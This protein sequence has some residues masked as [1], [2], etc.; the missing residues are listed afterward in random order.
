MKLFSTTSSNSGMSEVSGD[1]LQSNLEELKLSFG[2]DRPI[3]EL[4]ISGRGAV[5]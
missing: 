3:F 1:F 2:A 4:V 5:R